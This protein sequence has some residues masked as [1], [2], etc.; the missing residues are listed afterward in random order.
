M[1][2]SLYATSPA[3]SIGRTVQD[4]TRPTFST[5]SRNSTRNSHQD[6]P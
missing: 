3:E 5:L 1:K 6:H 4:L 2:R